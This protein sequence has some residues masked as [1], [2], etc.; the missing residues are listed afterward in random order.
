MRAARRALILVAA[1]CLIACD[2]D[3]F[4]TDAQPITG[5]YKLEVIEG[6]HYLLVTSRKVL[7][8]CGVI[9]GDVL[10]IGWNDR[11]ILFE[12]G[13]WCSSDKSRPG[14]MIVDVKTQRIEGP[15]DLAVIQQRP[16]LAAIEIKTAEAAWK[17][18]RW[19]G[20]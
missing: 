12:R 6:G 17:N 4:G 18:L 10:R 5:P 1:L 3:L 14:W 9:E 2:V 7:E 15:F 20:R 13:S 19:P 8:N 16:D 11:V